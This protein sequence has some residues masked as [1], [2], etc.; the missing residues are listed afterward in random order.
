MGGVD[1][2]RWQADALLHLTLRFIGEVGSDRVESISRAV[3]SVATPASAPTLA[4]AGVG[5]FGRP[6]RSGAL[7]AGVVADEKLVSLRHAVDRALEAV[8]IAREDRRFIPHVTLARLGRGA[9]PAEAF[10]AG[11]A[12]LSSPP[13]RVDE[14]ILY[15]SLNGPGGLRYLPLARYPLVSRPDAPERSR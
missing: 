11:H 13:F 3:G 14:M 7:W 9:G 6:G 5:R 8:G 4:I 12:D 15:E 10:L 2:A 1:G